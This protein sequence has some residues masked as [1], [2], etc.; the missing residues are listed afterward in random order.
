[1]ILS[2]SVHEYAHALSAWL[3]GTTRPAGWGD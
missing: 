1:M 3:L 2:L